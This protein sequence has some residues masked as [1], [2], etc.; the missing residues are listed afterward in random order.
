M[1]NQKQLVQCSGIVN[2]RAIYGGR[3]FSPFSVAPYSYTE[4]RRCQKYIKRDA[5]DHKPNQVVY[6]KAHRVTKP[7][8]PSYN[9]WR[10]PNGRDGYGS[11]GSR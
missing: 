6:C 10:F 1:T 9:A 11:K 5:N 7:T 4:Q 3:G 8:F 2:K